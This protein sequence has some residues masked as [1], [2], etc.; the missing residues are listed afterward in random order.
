MGLSA[1]KKNLKLDKGDREVRRGKLSYEVAQ[2]L[3][4]WHLSR[5]G[6]C[7]YLGEESSLLEVL[8]WGMAL[9]DLS[10]T[11]RREC[12]IVGVQPALLKDKNGGVGEGTWWGKVGQPQT[13]WMPFWQGRSGRAELKGEWEMALYC[14]GKAREVCFYSLHAILVMSQLEW[15]INIRKENLSVNGK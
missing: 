5:G 13:F 8:S 2:P 3:L 11:S 1:R 6:T 7:K 4:R 15:F 9:F 10:G 14:K 12:L